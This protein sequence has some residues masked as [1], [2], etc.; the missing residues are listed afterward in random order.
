MSELKNNKGEKEEDKGTSI[1]KE[2]RNMAIS[3]AA[4][5][6]ISVFIRNNVFA[7]A[8]V[9]YTSMMNT[10]KEKDV[11]FVEKL[12]TFTH[13][14]K[15]GE[16]II[17]D[18]H[19]ANNDTYIKRIIGLAGDTIELKDGDVY[20]NGKLLK[21]D[22]IMPGAKTEGEA[23]LKEGTVYKVPEGCVFAMGDNREVSLDC[24]GIGPVKFKDIKGHVVIRAYP[25]NTAKI[26]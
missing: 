4:A 23:F 10:L 12:C 2:I 9:Q 18:V 6:V 22:Y 19:N 14:Y 7:R 3:I 1:G 24:R 16:I 15:R 17:F 8:D 25:F 11:L 5:L 26:F 20:L 13:N 21:E